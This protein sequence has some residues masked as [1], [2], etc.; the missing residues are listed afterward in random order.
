M[1]DST[2]NSQGP[3]VLGLE[4]SEWRENG[5][6]W[7][8]SSNGRMG[9][10]ESCGDFEFYSEW[11][12]KTLESFEQRSEEIWLR[13]EKDHSDSCVRIIGRGTRLKAGRRFG[14]QLKFF[15]QEIKGG[16]S[17]GSEKWLAYGPLWKNRVYRICWWTGHGVWE[18]KSS[19]GSLHGF[20]SWQ[21]EVRCYHLLR[22]EFGL[23]MLSVTCSLETQVET[24]GKWKGLKWI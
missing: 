2:Q 9:W 16:S 14:N 1:P 18:K 17:G 3:A 20:P 23:G 6:K 22:R 11:A 7:L 15:R 10:D 5:R 13:F 12:G 19:Q 8:E 24:T 4:Q 21:M